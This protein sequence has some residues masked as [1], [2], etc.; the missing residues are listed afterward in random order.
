M[1]LLRAGD[2]L[3][4]RHA[5]EVVGEVSRAAGTETEG[6]VH[7]SVD[8]ALPRGTSVVSLESTPVSARPDDAGTDAFGLY[9]PLLLHPVAR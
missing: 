7:L 4:V 3:R 6:D 5:G 2:I 8:L 1:T 9:F